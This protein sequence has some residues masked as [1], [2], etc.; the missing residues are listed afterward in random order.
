MEEEMSTNEEGLT[1]VENSVVRKQMSTDKP[2]PW[3]DET[4]PEMERWLI[5]L[6]AVDKGQ[7][8]FDKMIDIAKTY[9][10]EVRTL[11]RQSAE[12]NQRSRN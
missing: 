2:A 3:E 12:D 11:I 7:L 8:D 5:M 4:I 6:D 9:S 10:E 1:K